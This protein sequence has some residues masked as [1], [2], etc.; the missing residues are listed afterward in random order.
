MARITLSVL[1][2]LV[3]SA[4]SSV[5][6]QAA[7]AGAG[8]PPGG[9]DKNLADDGIK[10]R[11]VELERAKQELKK[12]EATQFAP[13]NKQISARFPQIKEDFEGL[14]I[15]QAAIV[16]AYTTGKTIDYALIESSADDISKKAKRL[17]ANLFAVS[18]DKKVQSNLDEKTKDKA[19]KPTTVP[20]LIVDL[21]NAVGR[22]V[23]SKIFANIKIIEPDVAISTRTDLISILQ[24]SEK[25]SVEA[26]RLK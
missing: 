7:P 13:I 1:L 6:G 9:G 25:L 22:F 24:L 23:S 16:K 4:F 11:S 19:E 15:S 14:Q 3:A 20:D 2:I 10:A 17:D 5:F 26:R 18:A 8:T 12:A 21:D